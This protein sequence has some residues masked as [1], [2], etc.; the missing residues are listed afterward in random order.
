VAV[1]EVPRKRHTGQRTKFRE[2]KSGNTALEGGL[3]WWFSK[4]ETSS[5]RDCDICTCVVKL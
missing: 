5:D 1:E 4:C 3:D 2:L